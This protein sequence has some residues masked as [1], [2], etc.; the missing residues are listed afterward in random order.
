MA[1]TAAAAADVGLAAVPQGPF[2]QPG[3]DRGLAAGQ[4]DPGRRPR[5]RPAAAPLGQQPL[6]LLEAA[7]A[8]AQLGQPGQSLGVRPRARPLGHADRG[9]QLPLGVGPAALGQQDAP[10]QGAAAGVQERAAVAVDELVGHLAPLGR[11]LQVGGQVAGDQHVAAGEHHGVEAAAL[12]AE[13]ARHGLVDQGQALRL[14]AG[15]DQRDP[16]VAE[17]GQ[18]QVDVPGG[19]G[20]LEH[21]PVELVGARSG[22]GSR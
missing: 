21:A 6:R 3:G 1:S 20:Q 9:Q 8:Q 12:A 13:R 14:P 15:R 2:Q 7:L 16:Q 17:R 19:P 22:S 4:P 10:V 18:L 5:R 11:P